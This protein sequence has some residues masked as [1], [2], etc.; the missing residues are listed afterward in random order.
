MAKIGKW[1]FYVLQGFIFLLKQYKLI[2][3]NNFFI[4]MELKLH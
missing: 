2:S 3:G 1:N 4:L